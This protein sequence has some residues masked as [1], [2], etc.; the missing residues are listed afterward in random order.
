MKQIV[1]AD[2]E[3]GSVVGGILLD[4]GDVIMCD[5]GDYIKAKNIQTEPV[6]GDGNK[7]TKPFVIEEVFDDWIDLTQE[8]IGN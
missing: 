4:N 1:I 6:N 8:I 3:D 5:N 2:V 7:A